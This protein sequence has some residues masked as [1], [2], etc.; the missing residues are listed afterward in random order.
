MNSETFSVKF[1]VRREKDREKE[2]EKSVASLE[3][4]TFV[5]VSA[6]YRLMLSAACL[7]HLFLHARARS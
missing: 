4:D 6:V 2:R 5:R 7:R 3:L 1:T